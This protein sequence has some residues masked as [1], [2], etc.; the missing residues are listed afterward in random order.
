MDFAELQKR[1]L[2]IRAKYAELETH[3]GF[4]TWSREDVVR[5]FVGDVGALVKL[6]MAVDGL[7]AIPEAKSKLEH[8]LADCLYSLFAIAHTYEIS[9]EQSF[10]ATMDE[11]DERIAS[12]MQEGSNS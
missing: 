9:L 11:L 7:R 4:K 5:G 3:K 1:A 12:D 2:A 8:E 6:T 10:L